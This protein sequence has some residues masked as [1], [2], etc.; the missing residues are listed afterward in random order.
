[1]GFITAAI[2]SGVLYDML[3][4]GITITATTIKKKLTDWA[5]DEVVSDLLSEEIN[6]LQLD[7]Q[8][9]EEAIEKKIDQ[10]A[11][12]VM[13][14]NT[15]KPAESVTNI[16]QTHSGDGDNVAGDKNINGK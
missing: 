10:A 5:V 13:L 7:D 3:K 16:V 2:L 8:L 15:I 4:Q 11:A 12:L 14:M 9:N 6:K 1:M